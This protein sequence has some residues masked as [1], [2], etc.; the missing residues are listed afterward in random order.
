MGESEESEEG[1]AN[2]KVERKVDIWGIREGN[3]KGK[4]SLLVTA[5]SLPTIR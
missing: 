5:Q 3:E 2:H 4:E 1:R